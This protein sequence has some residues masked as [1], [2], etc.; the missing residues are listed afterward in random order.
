M[1]DGLGEPF[2]APGPRVAGPPRAREAP[3]LPAP[4]PALR[5]AAPKAPPPASRQAEAPTAPPEAPQTR[6]EGVAPAGEGVGPR[7]FGLGGA[8]G[9]GGG[10]DF[11]AALRLSG[12]MVC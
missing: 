6:A 5:K 7:I 3:P 8:P 10:G 4:P 1:F 9:D 12:E 11:A 2:A